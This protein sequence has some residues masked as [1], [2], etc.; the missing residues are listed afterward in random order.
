MNRRKFEEQLAATESQ[1]A[2]VARQA[3]QGWQEA[4]RLRAQAEALNTSPNSK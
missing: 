4:K 2:Q 3:R 1:V